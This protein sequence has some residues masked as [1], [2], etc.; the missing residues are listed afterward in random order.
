[1]DGLIV[2]VGPRKRWEDVQRDTL[3]VIGIQGWRRWA[4]EIAEWRPN[5]TEPRA[6]APYMELPDC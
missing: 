5:L 3:Q 1:M 2:Y 6:V 4:E